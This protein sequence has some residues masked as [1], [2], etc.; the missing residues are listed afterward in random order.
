M[1]DGAYRK[2]VT[3]LTGSLAPLSSDGEL[4]WS[5]KLL[6]RARDPA[7][8]ITPPKSDGT[9]PTQPD[10]PCPTESQDD[11]N[12]DEAAQDEEFDTSAVDGGLGK[13][14]FW[15]ARNVQRL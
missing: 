2:G 5:N 7:K 12:R 3:S 8:A 14:S 13:K 6:P 4:Q 1:L 9:S 15:Q 11:P 10:P